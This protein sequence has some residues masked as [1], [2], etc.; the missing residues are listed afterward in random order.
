MDGAFDFAVLT[1][2]PV[3][4]LSTARYFKYRVHLSGRAFDT[5]LVDYFDIDLAPHH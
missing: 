2:D 4:K 1:A 5:P 3:H